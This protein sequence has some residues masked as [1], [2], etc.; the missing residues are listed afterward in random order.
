MNSLTR[1]SL[2]T[3]NHIAHLALNR[4]DVMNTMNRAFWRELE[5]T[6]MCAKLSAPCRKS[7]SPASRPLNFDK[8]GL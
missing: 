7:A 1:F 3:A 4:P 5:A 2:T 6:G 8:L